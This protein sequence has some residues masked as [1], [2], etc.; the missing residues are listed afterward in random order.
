MG[1]EVKDP[2]PFTTVQDA[3]RFGYQK[4]GVTPS[5]PMDTRAF[6]LANLLVGNP[7]GEGA[8]EFTFKGPTL[9]FD[10]DEV[11]AITGGDMQPSLN[12][13]KISRYRAVAVHA[14]DVLTFSFAAAGGCRGY[15]AVAGGLDI[16]EV[17][18]SKSTLAQKKL[19]GLDGRALKAGDRIG[20]TAP[21]KNL[22]DLARRVLPV[23]EYPT[24][25]VVLRVVLGP[26][27]D[28]F[29]PEEQKKFFWYSFKV[30]N[31]YDRQGCRLEREEPV[32]HIKDGNIIT[33]G[34]SFGAIQVPSTGQPII[35]MA[36]RQ[37][38]GGYTKIGN[39]IAV[40]LPKLA[41]AKPGMKVRFVRVSIQTAQE[42][43]I[44]EHKEIR[45]IA[46]KFGA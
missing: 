13:K 10:E 39:V 38:T 31:E 12:G 46:E 26:Q 45:S 40:D 4:F 29:S 30:T 11:I 22:P 16:P 2:G 14:G 35:M 3:G 19:G 42:L 41:Q 15:I 25:E 36:D 7:A 20:L 24:D 21:K 32:K 6:Q 23:P 33:D 43:L 18:G 8:L 1:F 44:R 28:A 37:T 17:M 34:I 27:D 9:A 5:G